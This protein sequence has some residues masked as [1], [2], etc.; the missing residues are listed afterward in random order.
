M[1]S[2]HQVLCDRRDANLKHQ[3][4]CRFHILLYTRGVQP[5]LLK[6]QTHLNRLDRGL[7]LRFT[8]AL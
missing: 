7:R 1:H 8:Q 6:G 5:L 2:D 4:D 3:W